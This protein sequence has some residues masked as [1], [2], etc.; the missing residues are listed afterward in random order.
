MPKLKNPA[1][2]IKN[3][4]IA[5]PNDATNEGRA[6]NILQTNGVIKIQQGID[7]PTKKNI[8]ANPYG[9]E[10]V[11]LDPSMLPRVFSSKQVDIV[12][13]TTNLAMFFRF[14]PTKATL[15]EQK[16]KF[17]N[18]VAVRADEVELPKMKALA[19]SFNFTSNERVY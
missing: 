17:V 6:L 14:K 10:I 12:L 13:M 1:D 18:I 9:V 11:E 15:L 8:T 16:V 4:K 5:V 2:L 19:K 3:S 7:L